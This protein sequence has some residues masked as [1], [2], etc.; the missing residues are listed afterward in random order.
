MNNYDNLLA[1]I[2]KYL[3]EMIGPCTID[4][5]SKQ[6]VFSVMVDGQ[7]QE[8]RVWRAALDSP[9]LSSPDQLDKFLREHNVAKGLKG[10]SAEIE[11]PNE[12]R[13]T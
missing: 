5:R 9:W 2:S 3:E 8:L 11:G 6:F 1:V 10:A 13:Y 7:P 4:V 12:V